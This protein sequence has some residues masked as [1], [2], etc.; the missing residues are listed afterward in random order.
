MFA[1]QSSDAATG[2]G[3]G[4]FFLFYLVILVIYLVSMWKLFVKMG[5][6]GWVG[7]IPILNVYGIYKLAGRDWWYIILLFIPCVNLV[8]PLVPRQRHGQVLRQGA[9][10]DDPAVLL[11]PLGRA[12]PGV[13][14]LPVRGS[15]RADHLTHL[16]SSRGPG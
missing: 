13:R 12:D 4:V 11:P 15:E 16:I 5:Q 6:P 9:R 3:L 10:M 8:A 2:A 14:R 7:I 1:Q